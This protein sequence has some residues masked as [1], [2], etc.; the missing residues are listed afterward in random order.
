M[1]DKLFKAAVAVAVTPVAAVIDV[2]MIIP[3]AVSHDPKRDLPFS[4]T[5]SLL[6]AAGDNVT[7]AVKE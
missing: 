6:K 7:K 3:D 4:R 5:G 1:L 2:A